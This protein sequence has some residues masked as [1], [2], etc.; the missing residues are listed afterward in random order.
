M[1][2]IPIVTRWLLELNVG[3]FVLMYLVRGIGIDLNDSLGLH[4]ILASDFSLIQLLTYM[5][6][7]GGLEHIFFNMFALWMFGCLIEQTWGPR[8]YLVYYLLC[9]VGAGLFQEAAQMVSFYFMC[10]EQIPGFTLQMLGEVAK[11]SADTLNGWTTVGASGAV[12]GILLAFGMCYP[13]ERMFIFP[14]PIPIKAKWFVVAYFVI[15]IGLTLT[16]PGSNVAHLAHVGGM[17]VGYFLIRHWREGSRP[18]Y[19]NGTSW[20]EKLRRFR[21]SKPQQSD[22]SAYNRH[23]SDYSYNSRRQATQAEIDTILDKIRRSGYESLTK[24]E[25][26]KLFDMGQ[27][28]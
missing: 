7:H 26:Q 17:V 16:Q 18:H 14:L 6:M 21:V 15:E 22:D 4:F 11:N 25:K 24:E 8:R 12:Y 10:E 20:A 2:N 28:K 1:R 27:K 23:E 5:F 13:E 3:M 19:G 9:G